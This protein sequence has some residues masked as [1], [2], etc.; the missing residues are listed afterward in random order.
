MERRLV[1]GGTPEKWLERSR[2]PELCIIGAG[3]VRVREW[4]GG[5]VGGCRRAEP[6]NERQKERAALFAHYYR[7]ALPVI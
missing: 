6:E 7:Q 3:Y 5:W 2:G 1:R 4:E